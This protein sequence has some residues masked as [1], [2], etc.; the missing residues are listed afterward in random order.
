MAHLIHRHIAC[1][2]HVAGASSVF[3]VCWQGLLLRAM[4]KEK[5]DLENRLEAEQVCRTD[6][7]P[8][9]PCCTVR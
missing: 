6:A 3:G 8:V 7:S 9:S 1:H 4:E 2:I 5:V